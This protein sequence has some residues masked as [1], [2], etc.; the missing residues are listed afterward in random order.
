MLECC[1]KIFVITILVVF[2]LPSRHRVW[3]DWHCFFAKKLLF[4]NMIWRVLSCQLLFLI[5]INNLPDKINCMCDIFAED[6]SLFSS[7][8]D[9]STHRNKLNND[10]H[11]IKKWYF[12]GKWVLAL[13][14]IQ[15]AHFPRKIQKNYSQNVIFN[16]WSNSIF[17]S[18]RHLRRVEVRK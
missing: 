9:E 18:Q 11:K 10:F 4:V 15:K 12:K 16:G 13:I 5:Y 7:I 3:M 8:H 6:T 14:L 17:S 1:A 2:L